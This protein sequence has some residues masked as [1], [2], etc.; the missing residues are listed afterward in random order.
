MM[1]RL[2]PLAVSE[3]FPYSAVE[4]AAAHGNAEAFNQ[5]TVYSEIESSKTKLG[6]LWIWA[7]GTEAMPS[8]EFEEILQS[9]PLD[10]VIYNQS[11][12][13][14]TLENIYEN[15]E[16]V[17]RKTKITVV[18]LIVFFSCFQQMDDDSSQVFKS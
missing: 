11:H 5:L 10:E 7:S 15:I 4:I 3:G 13:R 16:V 9:I 18:S 14:G 17:S 1:L 2:D 8:N 12:Q 6:Q